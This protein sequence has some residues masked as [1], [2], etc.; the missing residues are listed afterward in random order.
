MSPTKVEGLPTGFSKLYITTPPALRQH[1][2]PTEAGSASDRRGRACFST[3]FPLL[4]QTQDRQGAVLRSQGKAPPQL[5]RM[6]TRQ[7]LGKEGK[8]VELLK[9]MK[10]GLCLPF[11]PTRYASKGVGRDGCG[12]HLRFLDFIPF[13][14]L[15][16]FLSLL[17]IQKRQRIE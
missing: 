12:C 10:G 17:L 16:R 7:S 15:L 2:R 3:A 11:D 13:L 1:C 14:L 5:T 6:L 8:E 4:V 9:I